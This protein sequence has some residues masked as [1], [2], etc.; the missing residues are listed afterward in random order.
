MTFLPRPRP[1]SS[2][3]GNLLLYAGCCAVAAYIGWPWIKATFM[4][5]MRPYSESGAYGGNRNHTGF[6]P[7]FDPFGFRGDGG[8]RGYSDYFPG[9][10][11]RQGRPVPLPPGA[12][13]EDN[14][15]PPEEG[16]RAE[17]LSPPQ[18]SGAGGHKRAC[19]DTLERRAV[20]PSFCER[21]R[22]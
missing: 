21:G 13:V 6:D 20:D 5:D 11:T 8:P 22:R 2:F 19:W 10:R 12:Y 16:D 3:S 9:P 4:P 15:H 18:T 17:R 1:P 7:P 14:R